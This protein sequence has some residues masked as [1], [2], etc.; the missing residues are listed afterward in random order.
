M[1]KF[2]VEVPIAGYVCIEVEAEDKNDAIDIAF[3]KGYTD[4]EI[5][6][7]DMYERLV[8]GNVVYTYHTRVEVNEL[9][10]NEDE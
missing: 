5:V 9:K 3:Q 8:E 1:K 10:E 6:E 7:L 2:I 4:E